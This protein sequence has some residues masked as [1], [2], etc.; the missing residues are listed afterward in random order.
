MAKILIILKKIHF[1]HSE[2]LVLGLRGLL[3]RCSMWAVSSGEQHD[4]LAHAVSTALRR[5]LQQRGGGGGGATG[6]QPQP[7]E[8]TMLIAV[9]SA[10][11]AY[12][13]AASSVPGL[14][15]SGWWPGNWY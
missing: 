5:S 3:T 6:Q 14:S 9:N 1:P 2:K 10:E 4:P 11:I 7:Q 15:W 8:E 12:D 13:P